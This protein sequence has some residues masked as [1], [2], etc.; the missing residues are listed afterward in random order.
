M[1]REKK[2]PEPVPPA[3]TPQDSQ[4][5]AVLPP[6]QPETPL[7]VIQEKE[8]S[9]A[10]KNPRP[11]TAPGTSLAQVLRRIL[12]FLLKLGLFLLLLAA[13]AAGVYFGWPIVYNQYVLPVQNHTAQ[14]AILETQAQQDRE[15]LSALQTRVPLLAT[16][17][18]QQATTLTE[19]A[20][21]LQQLKAVLESQNRSLADLQ[22]T[23]TGLRAGDETRLTQ[24][25]H[26]VVLLKSMELLSRA[27]LFLYQS[28]FGL[29]KQD[30]QAARELLAGTDLA[31][32][33]QRLDLTLSR[34]PDFPVPASGDLDIAWQILLQELPQGDSTPFPPALSETPTPTPYLPVLSL[35]PTFT[36]SVPALSLTTTSTPSVPALSDTPAPAS[37]TLAPG[38]TPYPTSTATP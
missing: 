26:E 30:I 7:A 5:L 13:L 25:E 37:L 31:E 9:S 32:V 22:A 20:S 29:A 3:E 18:A 1:P 34:L 17:Q 8:P 23:Q 11:A 36:P 10:D 4:A 35:T 15:Q 16:G 24:I 19:Q 12:V 2:S 28:N 6:D 27:R 21:N 38:D 14:L 33:V